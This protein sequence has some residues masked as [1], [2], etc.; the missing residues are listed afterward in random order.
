MSTFFPR[1]LYQAFRGQCSYSAKGLTIILIAL[2]LAFNLIVYI[3]FSDLLNPPIQDLPRKADQRESSSLVMSRHPFPPTSDWM[4]DWLYNQ[5]VDSK[6]DESVGK[7][8][9]IDVV[10]TWVNGSDPTLMAVK[11]RYE[12]ASPF[13]QKF[14]AARNARVGQSNSGLTANRYRDMD[15]LRYS[16][17]SVAEYA[18]TMFNRIHIL[19]TVVDPETQESQAPSWLNNASLDVIQLVRHDV[20]FKDKTLLPSFNS[21]AIESQI[22][23]IPMVT[24]VFLYL[25]DDVF[26]GTPMAAADVWTPLY[27]FVFHMEPT[28]LVPPFMHT[29]DNTLNV[30]EWDSLQYSNYLLSMQFGPRHRSYLA[31]VPHVLSVPL[32]DE[33][34]SMWPEEFEATSSHRF[35][36]EGQARDVHVSFFM[37]HY[38]AERLRETQ[39][40]SFWFNR[41]DANQDGIL[42]WSEREQFLKRVDNWN[43]V[44]YEKSTQWPPLPYFQNFSSFVSNSEDHLRQL[45]MPPT[46]SSTYRLSG[47]DGYPFMLASANTTSTVQGLDNRPYMVND[48]VQLRRCHLN[49]DFCLGSDFKS[50]TVEAIDHDASTTIFQRLAFTEFHCGDCLL[51]MLR[52]TATEPGLGS[53]ILP[54]EKDSKVYQDVVSDLTKYNYVIAMSSYTFVSLM[55]PFGSQ[56][57]LNQI[58]NK[59]A[60]EAFFC[61]NDNVNNNPRVEAQ[62][63]DIFK[64]FLD[65]RFPTSSPWEKP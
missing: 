63:R 4:S 3:H 1:S 46:G 25:N 6:L 42:D 21:L 61:I 35:R 5:T 20:I 34:Q 23:H 10:Y 41:L 57:F 19:T 28:L 36:G 45:G 37:A 58:M 52:Q 38:V 24:D 40:S 50:S 15:E 54:V 60:T 47:L 31:H 62:V 32:L 9:K 65:Q 26:L 13:F 59:K 22:H 43:Q 8:L 44:Q 30:G 7:G 33:I 12:D 64:R 55:D 49:I 53:E 56:T 48:D 11:E 27:G 16:V 39:L 18:S 17:R 14:R 29:P 2:F 51:H